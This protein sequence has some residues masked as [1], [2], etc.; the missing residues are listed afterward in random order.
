MWVILISVF[1]PNVVW[2]E[3]LQVRVKDNGN[4]RELEYIIGDK[5]IS[6]NEAK[7]NYN[8]NDY[9]NI[10]IDNE[11][12]YFFQ[13]REIKEEEYNIGVDNANA[14]E[15]AKNY[16]EYGIR[17]HSTEDIISN[18]DNLYAKR[19]GGEYHFIYS[20]NEYKSINFDEVNKYITNNYFLDKD[21]NVF[22]YTEYGIFN[23]PRFLY[24]HDE[25]ELIVNVSPIISLD[26]EK[27]IKE[28]M[29]AFESEFAGKSDYEKILIA[30]TYLS[31]TTTKSDCTSNISAY[32]ALI[33]RNAGCI[34]KANA[35][36]YIM[37]YLGIE[38]YIANNAKVLDDSVVSTH[39]F[40][41]VKLNDMYYIIDLTLDGYEGF[42]KTN[43]YNI[44]FSNGIKISEQDFNK[45]NLKVSIDYKKYDKLVEKLK[46]EE[47]KND[48]SKDKKNDFKSVDFVPYLILIIILLI[49]TI[50]IILF[51]R[52]R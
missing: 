27:K 4:I 41:I 29:N 11:N 45:D 2:A 49:I 39:T 19:L 28:F 3:S 26:E 48:S 52:K 17:V 50:I 43:D 35:F 6:F 23:Y 51:T 10:L 36:S 33:E 8:V 34:G 46:L 1:F 22:K 25:Y 38:S 16:Q 7:N 31:N 15:R 12:L 18:I 30:Y 32:D 40:N 9:F 47:N 44:N 21:I 24:D 37:E 5:K 14:D 20:K 42:L 13:G